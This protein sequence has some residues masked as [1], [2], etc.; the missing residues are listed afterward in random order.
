MFKTQTDCIKE[1]C[2]QVV[3]NFKTVLHDN[4]FW[5]LIPQLLLSDLTKIIAKSFV[6]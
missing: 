1:I 3:N 6:D 2:T 5:L 4:E